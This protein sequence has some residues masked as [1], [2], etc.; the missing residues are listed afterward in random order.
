MDRKTAGLYRLRPEA[1]WPPERPRKR[2]P[3]YVVLAALVT[4]PI[5]VM[6]ALGPPLGHPNA[7]PAETVAWRVD[8][9]FGHLERSFGN[10]TETIAVLWRRHVVYAS[11]YPEGLAWLGAGVFV[12]ACSLMCRKAGG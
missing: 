1:R 8:Q 2:W 9:A 6:L 4:I 12:L 7:G 3:T 11:W 5:A 10:A